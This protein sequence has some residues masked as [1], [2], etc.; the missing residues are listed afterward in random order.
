MDGACRTSPQSS[1]LSAQCSVLSPQPLPGARGV[2]GERRLGGREV[3]GGRSVRYGWCVRGR[4]F[5]SAALWRR[6]ASVALFGAL[7]A[8]GCAPSQPPRWAEGGAPLAFAPARWQRE[9]GSPVELRANGHVLVDGDLAFV[10]DRVGRVAND[11]YDPYAVLLP[12]G[13]LVGTGDVGL[14]RVGVTNA[15]PPGALEAWLAVTPDG[16]VTYFDTDGERNFGGTWQGCNGPVLRTCTLVTQLIAVHDLA[17]HY[18]GVRSGI[19]VGVG[20]GVGVGF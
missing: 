4:S 5:A 20:V 9:S 7:F 3:E 12:D 11:D 14:G 15:S 13:Q 8:F 6:V 19:G 2:R 1:V 16:R 18:H 10:L 17:M